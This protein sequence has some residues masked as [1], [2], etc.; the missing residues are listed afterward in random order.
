MIPIK[1]ASW[2]SMVSSDHIIIENF[3]GH[4]MK[5]WRIISSKFRWGKESYDVLFCL[6][7][8]LTSY[9]FSLNPLCDKEDAAHYTLYNNHNYMISEKLLQNKR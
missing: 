2:N 1:D 5:L 6:F 8:A 3:F 9:H 4:L 7:V